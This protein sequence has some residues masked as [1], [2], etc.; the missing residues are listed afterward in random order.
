MWIVTAGANASTISGLFYTTAGAATGVDL[1]VNAASDM[2]V[3]SWGGS[4]WVP[5]NLVSTTVA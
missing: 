1:Q 2:A 5:E 3:L 4:R